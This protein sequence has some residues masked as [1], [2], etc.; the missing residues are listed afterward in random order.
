MLK[1]NSPKLERMFKK[2]VS[3]LKHYNK[4]PKDINKKFVDILFKKVANQKR[5]EVGDIYNKLS[6]SKHFL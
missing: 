4:H 6:F 5:K 2:Y 1:P 3:S